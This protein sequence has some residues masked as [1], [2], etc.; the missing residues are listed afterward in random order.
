MDQ[1]TAG[2]AAFLPTVPEPGGAD[3]LG[4]CLQI[5]VVKDDDGRF[6]AE[7]QV[8]AFGG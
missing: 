7:F 3:A 8:H 1:D 6:A 5:G 4:G 2:R